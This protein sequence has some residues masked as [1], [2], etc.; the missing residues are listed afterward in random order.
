MPALLSRLGLLLRRQLLGPPTLS[1]S[2][3]AADRFAIVAIFADCFRH[4]PP[5]QSACPVPSHY[6]FLRVTGQ[7][8]DF[9]GYL[10][11]RL[12]NCPRH[13][14]SDSW[15]VT[16]CALSETWRCL[17]LRPVLPLNCT[18]SLI[19]CSRSRM[20]W[21]RGPTQ[22]ASSTW[23]HPVSAYSLPAKLNSSS[24]C[25]SRPLSSWQS[26]IKQSSICPSCW[27]ARCLHPQLQN[28]RSFVSASPWVFIR[29]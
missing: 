8:A 22:C 2:A 20:H 27:D 1:N 24:E 23:S 3:A 26:P 21:A 12:G 17:R 15:E 10:Q 28:P 13:H 14:Q 11:P 4:S 18:S 19:G 29:A 16:N 6:H 25:P 9:P 7:A 5:L